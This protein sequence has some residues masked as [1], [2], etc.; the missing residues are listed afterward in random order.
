MTEQ[1]PIAESA[2]G[3]CTQINGRQYLYFV[4][5]GYLGLQADPEVIQA[6]CEATKQYGIHSATTRAGFGH[7]PPTLEAERRLA[8]YFGMQDA[9]FFASGYASNAIIMRGLSSQFDALFLDE[10]S[11]YS[12]IEAAEQSRLPLFRFRHRD[13][14]ALSEVLKRELRAGQRPLVMSDGVFSVR[15][16]LAPVRPYCEVLGEY[17]G[18]GLLLDDA[19]GVAVLGNLGRGT[20]DDAGLFSQS[21]NTAASSPNGCPT[22]GCRLFFTATASKAIGGIGGFISGD[23]PFVKLL[24]E[25]SHWYDGASAPPAAASAATAKAIQLILGNPGLRTRLWANVRQFKDGLRES[26]LEVDSTPVPIICL[27]LDK[28]AHMQWIQRQLM[29]RGIAVAYT[30]SYASAGPEGCLRIAVFANHTETMIQQLLDELRPL[31]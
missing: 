7:I 5:T 9:F 4:G 31:L 23:R 25:S 28:A 24:K 15:G 21:V 26:G 8:D 17:V 18:G 27:A 16:T 6:A 2:P 14:Q 20:F 13:A 29:Q 3:P 30:R 10:L 19:H 12:L 22:D 11:H 1:P